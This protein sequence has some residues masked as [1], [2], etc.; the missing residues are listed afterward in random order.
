MTRNLTSLR[1][2]FP[3]PAAAPDGCA[4][5]LERWAAVLDRAPRLRPWLS[6]MIAQ[7]R[8]LLSE[9]AV[10]ARAGNVERAL[11]GDLARCV[12]A[13]RATAN[14]SFAPASLIRPRSSTISRGTLT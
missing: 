5:L 8:A 4:D 14:T 11:W 2:G 12:T 3:D 13:S 9:S 1:E 7:R 6:G 10:D